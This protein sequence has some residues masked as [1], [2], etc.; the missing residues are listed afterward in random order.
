MICKDMYAAVRKTNGRKWIDTRT[1]SHSID[2]ARQKARRED[3]S[4][5]PYWFKD[6]P[7]IYVAKITI[8]A[9]QSLYDLTA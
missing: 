1:I 4:C 2:N 5:G 9:G 8:E 3:K 6:N 7:A